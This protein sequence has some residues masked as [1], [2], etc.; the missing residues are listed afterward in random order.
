M[1]YVF[2]EKTDISKIEKEFLHTKYINYI[3]F[4]EILIYELLVEQSQELNFVYSLQNIVNR[5]GLSQEYLKTAI[6]RLIEFNLLELY[7]GQTYIFKVKK[8]L[9]NSEFYDQDFVQELSFVNYKQYQKMSIKEKEQNYFNVELVNILLK[10]VKITLNKEDIKKINIFNQVN[11][12]GD[13]ELINLIKKS[14][15]K[16]DNELNLDKLTFLAQNKINFDEKI[17][18]SLLSFIKQVSNNLYAQKDL[19]VFVKLLNKHHNLQDTQIKAIITYVYETQKTVHFNFID[20]LAISLLQKKLTNYADCIEFLRA[21]KTK[22]TWVKN[23]QEI[24]K[25]GTEKFNIE[26]LSRKQDKGAAMSIKD[27]LSKNDK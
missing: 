2:L 18:N 4:E 12:L 1:N 27:L 26:T 17:S 21:F 22:K 23:K 3:S 16:I 24:P 5:L 20:K 14:Y 13:N 9:I 11:Q 8:V 19:S 10:N 15:N 7:K 25:I 6:Q